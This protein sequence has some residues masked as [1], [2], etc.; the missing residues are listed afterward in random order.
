MVRAHSE[1]DTKTTGLIKT[2][3]LTNINKAET[4]VP[5]HPRRGLGQPWGAEGM[6]PAPLSVQPQQLCFY[7]FQTL[8][9]CLGFI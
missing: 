1:R 7:H 8:T 4:L 9:F 5:K 3:T 6:V 2:G